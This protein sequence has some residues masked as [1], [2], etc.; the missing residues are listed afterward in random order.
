DPSISEV[1][2]SEG[3]R[4]LDALV[5]LWDTH[6]E[7]HLEALGRAVEADGSVEKTWT[8]GGRFLRE[9]L[10]GVGEDGEPLL[11]L[12]FLGYDPDE[13]R[14]QGVWLSTGALGMGIHHGRWDGQSI[15]FEGEEPA[16]GGRRRFR[17][18]LT[19]EGPDRHVLAQSFRDLRGVW[20]PAFRITYTRAEP[21]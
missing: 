21:G 4:R 2:R 19:I 8:L 18:T 10:A 3:H 1:P 20:A 16:P 13:G 17:A 15:L 12:G 5:G 11:G 9:D 6:T 14:Y 7:L